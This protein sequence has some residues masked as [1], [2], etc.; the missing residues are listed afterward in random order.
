MIPPPLTEDQRKS[1]ELLQGI[2][3]R[4][5]THGF[6]LKGW[7]VTLVT[8]LLTFSGATGQERLATLALV[9]TVIFWALD[10]YL[11]AREHQYRRIFN[12]TRQ[13]QQDAFDFQLEALT[14]GT[15]ALSAFRPA[16]LV[17][18]VPVVL[19]VLIVAWG[20]V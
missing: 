10:A 1:L 16:M 3:G 19:V 18:Y 7:A 14:A 17:F 13:G 5:S 9:P 2:I 15:W 11:L 4:L 6:L 20:I 12:L 8:A